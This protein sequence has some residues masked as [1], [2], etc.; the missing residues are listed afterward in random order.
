MIELLVDLF[1]VVDV[2]LF[3]G[4]ALG[5]LTSRFT[6]TKAE[7]DIHSQRL[8]DNADRLRREKD[9]KYT[10]FCNELRN[11]AMRDSQGSLDL[12]DFH[13]LS[14]AGDLYFSELRNIAD[15][16]LGGNVTKE[17]I[18]KSFY[19][20]LKEAVEKSLPKYYETLNDIAHSLGHEYDFDLNQ[21]NYQSIYEAVKRFG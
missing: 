14:Q 20:P 6:R 16:C 21:G 4:G 13:K 15:A 7:K 3:I 11:A 5:Y 12:G 2:Q 17:A 10:D 19:N 8:F 9:K 18:R 1:D